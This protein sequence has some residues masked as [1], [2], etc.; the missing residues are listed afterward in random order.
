MN[1]L[2]AASEGHPFMK[3]G[4]LADVIGAL[5]KALKKQ[6][7]NVSVVMPKY[8]NIPLELRDKMV[9]QKVVNVPVGWRNQYGGIEKLEIDGIHYYFIDNETYF[10]R[11]GI[12]GY[13][14]DGERFAYFCRA[15]LEALPYLEER[16]DVIHCHDWQAGMIPV[17]LKSHFSNHPFY[18][19]IKTVFTIHNLQYQ[20]VF[21]KVVLHDLLDLS[22]LYFQEDGLE[23]H[24]NVS[25]LKAG[26]VYSDR[27]TTVSP[28]YAGEIQTPYYGAGLDGL[29]RKR[30]HD[31]IGIINGVDYE[32]YNPAADDQLYVQDSNTQKQKYKMENKR[33]LQE[34]L[35]FPVDEHIPMIAVVTRLV[36]QKGID[37]IVR[38]LPELLSMNVQFV[39]LGTGDSKYEDL[40]KEA[41]WYHPE[42]C[43]AH[44][45]FNDGFARKLY[46]ASDLFLMPS[47]IEPCGISQLLALRYGSL[48]LVRETG[49]L[50]DTVKPYNQYTEEG[51]GFSFASYNAHDMLYTIEQA[52]ALYEERP[53]TWA[54]L[55]TRA[56]DLDYSW[57][58]SSNK[59]K[60]LYQ[61]L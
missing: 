52:V 21:P 28:S 53:Y 46:A 44:I 47:R 15:V 23:Y 41:A 48:P 24:G 42:N 17:L 35:G 10:K 57:Q 45:Y 27:I 22:E 3:T 16:P 51:H 61:T 19:G 12:Y 13:P 8:K 60:Q 58:A 39:V 7:V 33:Q 49:G 29:L 59:Y 20:G 30:S 9:L 2:F 56:M 37:L 4:G 1:V 14:D 54:K 40:F 18:H 26:L 34:Q 50:K 11:D 32:L 38:I 25:F 36:D 43:S 31:L 5:P 55:V 6:G